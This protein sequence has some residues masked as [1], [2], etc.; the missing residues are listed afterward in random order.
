M[1]GNEKNPEIRELVAP[2]RRQAQTIGASVG[3]LVGTSNEI[4]RSAD[5]PA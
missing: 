3:C 5:A 4:E 1:F 2:R